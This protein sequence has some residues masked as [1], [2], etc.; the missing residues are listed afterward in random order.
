MAGL[1]PAV[2]WHLG[3]R[4]R[5]F[6]RRWAFWLETEAGPSL[7]LAI[8][9]RLDLR[10]RSELGLDFGEALVAMRAG[11]GAQARDHLSWVM[12]R[13]RDTGEQRNAERDWQ[14]GPS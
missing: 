4:L 1:V 5:D 7:K 6:S 8:N 10:I 9:V 13:N 3:V 2:A 14:E 11:A 12:H